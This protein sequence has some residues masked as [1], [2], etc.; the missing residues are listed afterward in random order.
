MEEQAGTATATILVKAAPHYGKQ[1]GELVCCAGVDNY[2]N[3]VRLFPVT[4]RY[5]EA[6]Q[7]FGRWQQ[8][9]FVVAGPQP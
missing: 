2:A 4:F 1:H 5:L 6:E 8:M 3:W 7:K 9:R